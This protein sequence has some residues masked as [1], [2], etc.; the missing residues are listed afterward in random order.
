M[1]VCIA[2]FLSL[3]ETERLIQELARMDI[4]V[5]NIIVNQLL[6]PGVYNGSSDRQHYLHSDTSHSSSSLII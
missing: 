5:R 3:Y 4:D 6:K 2:E 1:C